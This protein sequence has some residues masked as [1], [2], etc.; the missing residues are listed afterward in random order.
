MAM[1]PLAQALLA[2]T[3]AAAC[4]PLGGLLALLLRQRRQWLDAEVRHF[5]VALGGGILIAAVSLVLLPE[6]IQRVHEPLAVAAL[7]VAGG[8]A[9]FA[10]ERHLGVSRS[11]SPQLAATLLDYVPESLALGGMFAAGAASAPLLALLIGLQNLPEGFNTYLERTASGK[12][13]PRTVLLQMLGLVALGPALA[14]LGWFFL[15]AHAELL[16]AIMISA[17]GAIVYLIFQ[18]IA[19]MSRMRNHW[20]PPFGAVCGFGLALLG[21]QLI[22]A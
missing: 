8:A 11:D 13:K 16:G 21:Q 5:V 4:I 2:I 14:A 15:S 17:A 12:H 19:P 7:F 20:F 3:A 6:G 22:G 18:D 1:T 10:L 9:C